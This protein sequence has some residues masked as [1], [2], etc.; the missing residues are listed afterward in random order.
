MRPRA[1]KG[2]SK[3]YTSSVAP[4]VERSKKQFCISLFTPIEINFGSTINGIG[5]ST[6]CVNSLRASARADH[7][8]STLIE[9]G[10]TVA[11]PRLRLTRVHHVAQARFCR[12]LLRGSHRLFAAEE[13]SGCQ[14][15]DLNGYHGPAD[16]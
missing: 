10:R 1:A 12:V 13:I 14:T 9:Q 2:C 7:R 4:I 15:G 3:S 16:R 11:V 8:E 5:E 6:I